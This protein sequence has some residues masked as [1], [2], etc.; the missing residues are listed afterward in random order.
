MQPAPGGHTRAIVVM[1]VAVGVFALMDAGLKLLVPHYP[2][3]QIA[4]LRGAAALP[5]VAVWV[6]PRATV[7]TM[8]RVR[9]PLH[10]LR[11]A[12]STTMMGSFVFA[13]DTMPLATAYT[14]FFVGPILVGALSAPLLGERP[15]ARAWIAIALGIAGVLVVL[16]PSGEG[17]FTA[18]GA[19]MI[20]AAA[21]YALSAITVRVLARSDGTG[22]MVWWLTVLL[23]LAAGALAWPGWVP[24]A[25]A[26]VPIIVGV[27]A[28]GALG[29]WAMTRAFAMGPPATIAALEYTALAWGVGLDLA[30]WHVWP[31]LPTVLGAL[32]IV[33]SGLLLLRR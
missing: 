6:L 31:D 27:G 10:L 1:L 14:V 23:T 13:L 19:A 15:T 32:V 8:L 30:L 28:A 33:G 9:W 26:H 4:A 22:A 16:R 7:R 25:A 18:A 11:G 29:Q 21:C 12:L 17:L 20:V 5:F 3:L 24:I 2:P